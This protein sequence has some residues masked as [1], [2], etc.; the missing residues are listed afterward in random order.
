MSWRLQTLLIVGSVV[1]ASACGG[2]T[3]ETGAQKAAN[4]IVPVQTNYVTQV[5]ATT[6]APTTVPAVEAPAAGEQPST[7]DRVYVVQSGDGAFAIA[8]KFNITP[9]E[10][11][12]F[13]GWP[14]GIDH[15]FMAGDRVKIPPNATG[16]GQ[17]STEASGGETEGS[18]A[19]SEGCEHT[20]VK[21]ENPTKLAKKYKITVAELMDANSDNPAIKTFLIGSKIKIPAGGSC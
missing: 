5:P 4:R 18:A 11:V 6:A 7:S 13:N 15:V 14:E 16:S 20:V 1:L 19:P 21:G 3:D 17:T 10:L 8:K 12:E 2:P 9:D